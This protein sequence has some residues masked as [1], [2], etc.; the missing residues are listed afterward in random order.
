MN[1]EQEYR[2]E[3]SSSLPPR[4]KKQQEKHT[5]AEVKQQKRQERA[6]KKRLQR[7]QQRA[8]M[9]EAL[10]K[11]GAT[12]EKGGKQKGASGRRAYSV[13]WRS[14]QYHFDALGDISRWAKQMQ[15]PSPLDYAEREIDRLIE[16]AWRELSE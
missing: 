14:Q 4:S 5:C 13:N 15:N 6:H 7:G 9:H 1:K 10:R 3:P 8:H 12:L 11:I 16:Q 2:E